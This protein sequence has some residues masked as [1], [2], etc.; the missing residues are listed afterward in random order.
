M[1]FNWL[2]TVPKVKSKMVLWVQ[3]GC[4]CVDC[5]LRDHMTGSRASLPLPGLLLAQEKVNTENPKC[6]F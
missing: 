3:N 2:N 6:G 5:L 4:K 1:S